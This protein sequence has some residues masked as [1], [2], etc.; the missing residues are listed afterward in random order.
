[1]LAQDVSRRVAGHPGEGVGDKQEMG[2]GIGRG[3]GDNHGIFGLAH[4]SGEA[5]SS[6]ADARRVSNAAI[7]TLADSSATCVS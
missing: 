2:S 6:P 3:I 1:V 7:L 5:A 4:R